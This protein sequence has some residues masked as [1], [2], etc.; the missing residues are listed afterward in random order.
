MFKPTTSS[1]YETFVFLFDMQT[2]HVRTQSSIT[3][4]HSNQARARWR[5]P[6][7]PVIWCWERNEARFAGLDNLIYI[8]RSGRLV[9]TSSRPRMTRTTA[10]EISAASPSPLSSM[11][12]AQSC[13]DAEAG[14]SVNLPQRPAICGAPAPTVVHALVRT[15]S[16]IE[17]GHAQNLFGLIA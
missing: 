15:M 8:G 2:T 5:G 13:C 10:A 17:A 4:S 16:L 1:R 3:S 6:S 11:I 7:V 14:F 9:A 12:R